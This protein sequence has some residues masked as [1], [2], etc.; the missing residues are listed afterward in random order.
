MQRVTPD[1]RREAARRAR[2]ERQQRAD[3]GHPCTTALIRGNPTRELVA[4]CLAA[5]GGPLAAVQPPPLLPPPP[6]PPRGVATRCTRCGPVAARRDSTLVRVAAHKELQQTI[7]SGRV[8][9]P[10][11][12]AGQQLHHKLH[13]IVCQR[14][15]RHASTARVGW[16]ARTACTARAAPDVFPVAVAAGRQRRNGGRC[17]RN[18]VKNA[19]L[20]RVHQ[21][22]QPRG[23][24]RPHRQV[25]AEPVNA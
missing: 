20:V 1:L 9:V 5:A 2:E 15:G 24:C 23:L 21:R 17:Q 22:R 16:T 8:R 18:V 7:P 19:C 4:T 14:S 3:I 11:A 12:A 13:N 25:G 10:R 6:P